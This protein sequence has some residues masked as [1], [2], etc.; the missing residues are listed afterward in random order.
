M[1]AVV[2]DR[3]RDVLDLVALW[4]SYQQRRAERPA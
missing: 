4:E 3:L 1:V 2:T